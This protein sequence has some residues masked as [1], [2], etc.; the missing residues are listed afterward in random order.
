MVMKKIAILLP[1]LRGGGAETMRLKLAEAWREEYKVEFVLLE[2]TGE[3]LEKAEA[4][5]NVESLEVR[6]IRGLLP[7]LKTYVNK[8]QPDVLLVAMWPLTAIAPIAVKLSSASSVC[9]VSEHGIISEEQRERGWRYRALLGLTSMVG[10]RL[11][12]V[13]I[14]VSNGVAN[15]MSRVSLMA[16]DS[17][18]TI[19]N[20]ACSGALIEK[21]ESPFVDVTTPIIISVGKFKKVKNHRLLI[22]AFADLLKEMDVTLCLLGEG[23]LESEYLSLISDLGIANSVLMPG[24]DPNPHKYMVHSDLF[25]LSS[26]LEGFANVLVE[27]MQCGVSI[28]STDCKSG[29]REVLEDGKYGRLVPVGSKEALTNAMRSVLEGDRSPGDLQVRSKDFLVSEIAQQYIHVM[30]SSF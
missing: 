3:L 24:Y 1:D 15:D 20:P 11:A 5:F 10:Y 30:F 13:R 17:F 6:R 22:L 29:P 21:G 16:K 2:R 25:V 12:D 27:A 18:C 19:Y 8:K 4:N 26:D 23:E 14:G 9:V 7:A 28:V